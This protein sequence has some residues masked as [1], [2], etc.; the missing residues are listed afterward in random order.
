M[1]PTD[2]SGELAFAKLE[3]WLRKTAARTIDDLWSAI[4]QF[5]PGECRN[6]FQAAGCDFEWPENTLV[7][8]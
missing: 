7:D 1:P 4:G 5:T 2:G 8:C 3:A 6:D